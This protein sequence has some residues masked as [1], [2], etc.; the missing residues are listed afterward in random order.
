MLQAEKNVGKKCSIR[1]AGR[2]VGFCNFVKKK[3]K[4]IYFA[5][6]DVKEKLTLEGCIRK[7]K[8]PKRSLRRVRELC[9][10]KFELLKVH[11]KCQ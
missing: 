10:W 9:S 2:K 6:V 8:L 1:A 7:V 5:T 3:K 4:K 11:L